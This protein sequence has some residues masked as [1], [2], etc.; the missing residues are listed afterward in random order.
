M[1]FPKSITNLLPTIHAVGNVA[2]KSISNIQIL[3]V[4]YAGQSRR[5]RV[6]VAAYYAHLR[7]QVHTNVHVRDYEVLTHIHIRTCSHRRN[8]HTY[9]NKHTHTHRY[10]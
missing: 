2:N 8:I 3:M 7:T 9:V 5:I 6:T 10:L 1:L 4:T